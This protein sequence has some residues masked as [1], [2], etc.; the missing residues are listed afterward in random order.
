MDA[1]HLL[2]HQ[3]EEWGIPVDPASLDGFRRLYELLLE[4]NKKANL[5]RI[6][7]ER[8]AIVKHFL[9]SISVLRAIPDRASALRFID[10]GAGP[11]FPGLPLLVMQRHWQGTM[12][13]ATRKKV[14]FMHEAIQALGLNGTALHGRAEEVGQ[15]PAHRAGYDLV[16]ARAVAELNVLCELCLPF[17]KPGGRFIAMKGASADAEVEGARKALHVLGGS[18]REIVRFSLP[19]GFGERALVVVEKVGPTPKGYPRRAGQPSAKPLC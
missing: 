1:W 10:V 18:I 8:E 16:F 13:E 9:D 11:G 7:D 14:D 15:D 6:T 3:A 12:L 17:L 19:E 2:S 4:G 5:T